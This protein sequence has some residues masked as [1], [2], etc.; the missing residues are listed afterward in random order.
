MDKVL[1][2]RDLTK[3]YPKKNRGVK[4]IS[5]DIFKGDIYGLL[6][7]NGAGKTTII[8]T[9][10]GLCRADRGQVKIMGFDV[11]RQ[12]EQAM[13]KVGCIIETADAYEYLSGYK[14]LELAIRFYPNLDQK[15]ID[16]VLEIVGLKPYK[17]EPVQHYSLGMKQR[18]ALASALL[19]HP[20]LVMLDEPMNGLDIEGMVDIRKMIVELAREQQATFLI[21]S[22]L[23][24][25]MEL[26]CNRVGIINNGRLIREG[27]VSELLIEYS[28]LEEFF[29]Q[30]VKDGREAVGDEQLVS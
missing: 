22:H 20:E 8:K 16:E 15:R 19:S 24:Y 6:G 30:Q 2:V 13:A 7:P 4:G 23:A 10:T 3:I 29:I 5:F 9:I 17:N 27:I 14:N 1:E 28:S 25:E 12:F 26:T 11:S 18:L 21:S